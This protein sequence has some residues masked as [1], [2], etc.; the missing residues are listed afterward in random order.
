MEEKQ[1]QNQNKKGKY[2]SADEMISK[3][4]IA[5]GNAKLPTILPEL[6]KLGYSKE[7]LNGFMEK[8]TELEE[9][10]QNQKKEYAEQYAETEKFNKK[11]QEIDERYRRHLSLCKI[12]FKGDLKAHTVLDL[13]VRRKNAYAAWFQQVSNFYGQLLSNAELLTKVGTINIQPTDLEAQ[14]AALT[15][16]STL[17]ESQKKETS[18]A[19]KATE[20]RDEAL[21]ALYPIYAELVAYAKVLFHDDQTL[22]ALGIIVKR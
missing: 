11:R 19:Q 5:F 12:L 15:A 17:K 10:S 21:D 3:M 20:I 9:L 6:E 22:E 4:K 16:L 8:L 1:N 18:E 7:K 2:I 14:K 13:N